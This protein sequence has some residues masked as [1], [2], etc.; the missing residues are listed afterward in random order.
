[1]FLHNNER[2]VLIKK[3]IMSRRFNSIK[4]INY[5]KTIGMK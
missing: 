3:D 1:M 4:R 2:L 5:K